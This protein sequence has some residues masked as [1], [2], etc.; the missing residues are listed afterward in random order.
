MALVQCQD[1]GRDVS[2]RA[3]FCVHCGNPYPVKR[4]SIICA[5]LTG[6]LVAMLVMGSLCVAKVACMRA[7]AGSCRP[8]VMVA[9]V[10][11]PAPMVP[12]KVDVK[13]APAQPAAPAPA[14]KQ[15]E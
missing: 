2:T 14:A 15:E 9:P 12:V 6:T 4:C 11:K 7:R 8:P 13:P 1:C 5:V 10:A 3:R